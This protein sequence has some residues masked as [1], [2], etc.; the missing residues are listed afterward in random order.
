MQVRILFSQGFQELSVQPDQAVADG[1]IGEAEPKAK[2]WSVRNSH[3][4]RPLSKGGRLRMPQA[5]GSGNL[6]A[7]G[8]DQQTANCDV[9]A[10]P[11]QSAIP[12]RHSVRTRFARDCLYTN[13]MVLA[14]VNRRHAT[15]AAT[16][17][18]VLLGANLDLND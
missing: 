16:T 12:G 5:A 6:H 14:T 13:N 15:E 2:A 18:A 11:P 17:P 4:I 8:W 7:G 10:D 9:N 3:R 1:E